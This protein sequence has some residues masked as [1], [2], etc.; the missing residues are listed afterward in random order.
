[1]EVSC[2]SRLIKEDELTNEEHIQTAAN[3]FLKGLRP[4]R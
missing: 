1:M 4:E 2:S 3:L